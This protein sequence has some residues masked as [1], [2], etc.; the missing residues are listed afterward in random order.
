MI[1]PPPRKLPNSFRREREFLYLNEIDALIAA[2]IHSRAPIRNQ[3][4]VMLLFCQAL[5]PSEICSL[6]W[7]DLNKAANTL[8]IV[9]NRSKS[10]RLQPQ[11]VVNQQPL[12]PA[13]TEILQEL[14]N[15]CKT[16]WIL[17]SER[18]QRL[19]DRSL[20]HIVYQAGVVADLPVPVHPY[21]LR[22]SGLYYRAALLLQTA[23][24]SLHECCLLWNYYATS[25][26]SAQLEYGAIERKKE[27]AFLLAFEQIKAFAGIRRVIIF[28]GDER[29]EMP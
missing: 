12:C 27:E 29:P 25:S 10:L 6:R 20:H 3:A 24:L 4:L 1:K 28:G 11:I 22:R 15:T 19:S 17:E 13:E 18:Q 7:C 21:M 5:Q 9:R 8:L 16:D 2:S 23:S 14:V 26:P